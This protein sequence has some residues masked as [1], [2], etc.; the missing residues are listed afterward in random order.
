MTKHFDG[1][2]DLGDYAR[3]RP[4]VGQLARRRL[5]AAR[6]QLGWKPKRSFAQLVQEMVGT[7]LDEARR[8]VANG[9]KRH[10][11]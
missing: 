11:T 3:F 6:E 5:A 4:D 10:S 1:V 9:H 7:D 8:D 2:V